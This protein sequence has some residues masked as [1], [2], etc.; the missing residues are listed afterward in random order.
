MREL[1]PMGGG[2]YCLVVKN[3]GRFDMTCTLS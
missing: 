1:G 2:E 3:V